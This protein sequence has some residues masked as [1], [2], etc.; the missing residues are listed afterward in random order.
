MHIIFVVQAPPRPVGHGSN[1]RAYQVAF[2]LAEAVGKENLTIFDYGSEARQLAATRPLEQ[3]GREQAGRLSGA[4]FERLRR[5]R[6]SVR[7]VGIEG[8]GRLS[9]WRRL[10]SLLL[11]GPWGNEAP[12]ANR[13]GSRYD[14]PRVPARYFEVVEGLP[15]PLV[16]V[17]RHSNFAR[18]A[19]ANRQ[20]GIQT[21]AC[22]ANLEALDVGAGI[23]DGSQ[24][25]IY[26]TALNLGNELAALAQCAARLFISRVETGLV[27]GLGL[28]S[29]YYPYR[30]V[31][32]IRQEM[33]EIRRRRSEAP[34]QPGLFVM[35]GSGD[36]PTTAAAFRWFLAE[37][38]RHGLPPGA[39]VVVCGRATDQLG[40]APPG[41]SLRGWVEQEELTRLLSSAEGV[42][43][44]Q[45]TGFGA[46]TRLAELSC[47]GVPGIVSV[48]AT[49]A[50]QPMPPGFIP[51]AD[52][53]PRWRAAM[54]QLMAGQESEAK[55]E[56][57]EAW[58]SALP[59]PWAETLAAF[60]ASG[61]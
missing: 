16:C 25:E 47:A 8:Q 35:L 17:V 54:Q 14:D 37:A 4:H 12:G 19:W 41:V 51:V 31:G 40:D 58:E 59:R 13:S 53:W 33:L 1:H 7:Q 39:Q 9:E 15:R 18:L 52:G 6:R 22:V 48:H 20:R 50:V 36:H 57:Y 21:V 30:A 32:E 45:F 26:L 61:Q 49:H 56:Q 34:P 24:R 60:G 42:L 55:W 11:G 29:A 44:P 27:G 10:M 5:L 23:G 28:P 46:L 3:F 38:G 43:M 2:D